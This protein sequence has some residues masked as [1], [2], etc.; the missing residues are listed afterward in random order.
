[1][2]PIYLYDGKLLVVDSKLAGNE[3]CC[4]DCFCWVEW[5]SSTTNSASG[6][7][8]VGDGIVNVE[9]TSSGPVYLRTTYDL[10]AW[11]GDCATCAPTGDALFFSDT[12]GPDGEFGSGTDS[13][14]FTYSFSL[15]V[16][17]N[18]VILPVFSLGRSYTSITFSF[19]ESLNL[20]NASCP[21]GDQ[22]DN[23]GFTVNGSS[24]TGTG[25]S[26]IVELD[27]QNNYTNFSMTTGPVAEFFSLVYLGIPCD[28]PSSP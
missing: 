9:V 6:I 21:L 13:A 15:S 19:S 17:A 16:P 2:S 20:V 12:Q 5:Q 27:G 4:C 1:M 10:N 8:Q 28:T 3:N 24:I 14:N 18:R 7:I 26:S 23:T 22:Y 11:V 25:Q